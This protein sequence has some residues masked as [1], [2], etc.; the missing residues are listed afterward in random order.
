MRFLCFS[1]VTGDFFNSDQ[2]YFWILRCIFLT[3]FFICW[4]IVVLCRDFLSFFGVEVLKIGLCLFASA[5]SINYF[6]D[7]GDRWFGKNA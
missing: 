5:A 2:F 6:I 3:N 1:P 7:Y 4:A